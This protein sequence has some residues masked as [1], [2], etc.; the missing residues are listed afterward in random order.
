MTFRNVLAFQNF[1]L[2]MVVIFGLQFVDRSFGPVLPLYVEQVGVAHARVA[3]VSGVLFSIMACTR[4]ARPSFLR[5]AAA[6]IS[7]PRRDCRRR[8]VRGRRSAMVGA[9]GNFWLM[10][11]ASSLLGLGIGAAMTAVVQ[12]GGQRDSGGRARHRLR[13]AD[14][15][16][17][18]RHGEQPVHRGVLGG[19]SIRVV[20][21]VDV[22][23]MAS[24][25]AVVQEDEG[26]GRDSRVTGG[27]TD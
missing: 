6:A 20:F 2:M 18:R 22:A 12:R 21:V 5:Q 7:D 23:L 25:A 26:V 15:R 14:Q 19:T 9:S 8:G 4:R 13:R 24:M 16:V 17:A 27:L 3:M 10:C 1:I 11:A